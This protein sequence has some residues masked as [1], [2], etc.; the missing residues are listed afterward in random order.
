MW[1]KK[2]NKLILK[3][4]RTRNNLYKM[5]VSIILG[6]AEEEEA[7]KGSALST[8]SNDSCKWARRKTKCNI[9]CCLREA[10][11][12]HVGDIFVKVKIVKVV[13]NTYI[14]YVLDLNR[15]GGLCVGVELYS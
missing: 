3:G 12:L 7:A 9:Y 4:G 8:E 15:V 10:D 1:V 2:D 6:G 5:H 14:G 13:S 11:D